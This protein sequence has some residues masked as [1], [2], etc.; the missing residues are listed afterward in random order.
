MVKIMVSCQPID[1][2]PN[3]RSLSWQT[4]TASLV[5]FAVAPHKSSCSDGATFAKS[6]ILGMMNLSQCKLWEGTKASI[7]TATWMDQSP[8][9][10]DSSH[11]NSWMFI[12]CKQYWWILQDHRYW[13]ILKSFLNIGVALIGSH[14]KFWSCGLRWI[15]RIERASTNDKLEQGRCKQIYRVIWEWVKTYYYQ[16]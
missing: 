1:L 2:E 15:W 3:K 9:I 13:S 7:T 6:L 11:Q 16:F 12:Q 5:Q 10:P 14:R 4:L 8:R